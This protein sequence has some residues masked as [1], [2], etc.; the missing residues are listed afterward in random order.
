MTNSPIKEKRYLIVDDSQSDAEH[1][2]Q[3]LAHLSFLELAGI[4][5]TIEETIHLLSFE[6]IDLIF[7]D[8]NLTNQSGLNLLRLNKNLPPVIITSS[9]SNYALESYEIGKTVDYLLKPFTYER[10]L[11]ALNRALSTRLTAD[12]A[13]KD[14]F[15]FLK[16]GRKIQ[17][18]N[19]SAI[20]YIEAYG[21]Y[22]KVISQVQFHVVN[23][24]LSTLTDLLL[25]RQFVRVHKSYL[26][27]ISKITSYDRNHLWLGQAKI[28][29]GI[30]FRHKLEGLLRIFDR[31]EFSD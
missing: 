26:V 16:I 1:L 6:K 22:S 9:H 25:P 11:V 31:A 24:R 2:K 14:S 27:N 3:T 12:S 4:C 29:I 15:I 10:L 18:F 30:S 7:L 8:I 21:I 28:P 13:A 5:S 19:F 17:R 23:E 20:E